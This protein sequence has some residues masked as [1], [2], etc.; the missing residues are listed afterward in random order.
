MGELYG[1]IA[2]VTGAARGIGAAIARGLAAE[3][4]RVIVTDVTAPED[5]ALEIGGLASG[6]D[7]TDEGDWVEALTLAEEAGGLDILVNNAAIIFLKSLTETSLQDWRRLH[8]VNL[9]G[10]FLGC[11]YALPLL[12][13]R[14]PRCLN[15]RSSASSIRACI[16]VRSA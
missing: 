16:L 5:L 10:V 1:R 9:E 12:M 7:V 11:R 3:G 6:L 4:A 15:S 13:E 14:A 2:L 8:S